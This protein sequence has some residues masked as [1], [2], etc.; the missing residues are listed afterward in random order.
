MR[1]FPSLSPSG[2]AHRCSRE[3]DR[4]FHG[5][6]Y[7]P[8]YCLE[9]IRRALADRNP[10]AWELVF[11]LYRPLVLSWVRKHPAFPGCGEED[12][13]FLNRAFERL[14]SGLTPEK[15]DPGA[16]L[17]AVLDYLKLCVHSAVIDY[18]RKQGPVPLSD[19]AFPGLTDPQQGPEARAE[20]RIAN[21]KLWDL[22]A[23]K[24]NGEQE[25]RFLFAYF[26]LDLKPREIADEYPDLFKNVREVYRTREN[27]LNRLGR[28]A[29]LVEFLG[30]GFSIAGDRSIG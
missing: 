18:I 27:I 3:S 8:A 17:P 4:F 1:T 23:T 5:E 30:S 26:T 24:M 2:L 12:Q 9:L 29:D 14:W 13:Y 16:E 10:D 20:R 25:L 6:A 19:E 11:D 22:L 28:D 7:D 21:R 15:Y